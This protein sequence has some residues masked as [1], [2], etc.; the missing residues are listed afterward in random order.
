LRKAN[1]AA[2]EEKLKAYD[3]HKKLQIEAKQAALHGRGAAEFAI[4]KFDK[5]A[6]L[7]QNAKKREANIAIL[8]KELQSVIAE[9]ALPNRKRDLP[10]LEEKK[11][12]LEKAI[13]DEQKHLESQKK[14]AEVNARKIPRN[15][16]HRAEWDKEWKA[17]V[18]ES[19]RTKVAK[20]LTAKPL[21]EELA[22]EDIDLDEE[23]SWED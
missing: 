18:E 23:E 4:K 15:A 12:A 17:A 11:N 13:I 14:L 2:D 9:Q 5:Q 8:E 16:P 20:D 22:D 7:L 1:Y 6:E 21:L 10:K 19:D 3:D